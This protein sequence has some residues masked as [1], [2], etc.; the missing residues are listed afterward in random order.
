MSDLL[1]LVQYHKEHQLLVVYASEP[2]VP[3]FEPFFDKQALQVDGADKD[4]VFQMLVSQ[5]VPFTCE[6]NGLEL[7]FVSEYRAEKLDTLS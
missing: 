2:A 7:L 6:P 4:R 1:I 3:G 5:G